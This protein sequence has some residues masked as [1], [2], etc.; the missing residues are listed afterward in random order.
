[1][2]VRRYSLRSGISGWGHLW[3]GKNHPR[4]PDGGRSLAGNDGTFRARKGNSGTAATGY[5]SWNKV[6]SYLRRT[7]CLLTKS[8]H[9]SAFDSYV[10]FIINVLNTDFYV[11]RA[12]VADCEKRKSTLPACQVLSRICAWSFLALTLTCLWF[13]YKKCGRHICIIHTAGGKE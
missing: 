1:M 12:P 13:I 5:T 3:R 6:T 2:R 4:G 8:L 10:R 7:E 9:A 11:T